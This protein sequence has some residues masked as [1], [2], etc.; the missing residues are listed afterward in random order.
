MSLFINIT[1]A[2]LWVMQFVKWYNYEHKHSGIG[3]VSPDERHEGR[4]KE[5]LKHRHEVYK[6]AKAA[7]PERWSREI[8]KWSYKKEEWLNP[9]PTAKEEAIEIKGAHAS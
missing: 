8:R 9:E 2:R 7:H 5:I 3:Y 6:Q 4:D 1:E